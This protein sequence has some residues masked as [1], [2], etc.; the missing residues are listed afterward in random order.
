MNDQTGVA[1]LDL[2]ANARTPYRIETPAARNSDPISSHLAAA[3]VTSNGSRAHQRNQASR[4]VQLFPGYTSQELCTL[5][6]L[7]RYMLA[8]RLP[9]CST[10]TKGAMR[11]CSIT[12]RL[13]VTWW[14]L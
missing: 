10:V 12:G 9:E 4:A 5:T 8:R 14:P 1:S 3:R 7:D 6:H 2:F 13:A 11:A